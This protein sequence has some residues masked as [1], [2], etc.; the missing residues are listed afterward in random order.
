MQEEV[1]NIIIIK[2]DRDS[3]KKAGLIIKIEVIIGTINISEVGT[4]LEV[5]EETER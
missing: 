1:I 2:I 5:I 3:M 4:T